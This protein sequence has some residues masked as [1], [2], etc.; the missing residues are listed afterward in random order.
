MVHLLDEGPVVRCEPDKLRLSVTSKISSQPLQ[1]PGSERIEGTDA[2]HVDCDVLRRR[3]FCSRSID[4]LLKYLSMGSRPRAAR[5][6]L[7]Q[8]G[9][10]FVVQ[11]RH[12]AHRP[13]PA[14]STMSSLAHRIGSLFQAENVRDDVL[15][16][17]R[18]ENDIRHRPM[19]GAQNGGERDGR[20]PG[21]ARHGLKCGSL[22]VRRLTLALV[23][24][25]TFRAY[26]LG[27]LSTL[28][29]TANTLRANG[30]CSGCENKECGPSDRPFH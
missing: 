10:R 27:D 5:S 20:H 2:N 26:P 12:H 11:E 6:K 18:I 24:S 14:C 23:N 30:L 21:S 9:P 13:L 17:V 29:Q 8:P 16:V 4:Q 3:D 22:C 1:E 19:R 7:K 15:L 25:M 28:E